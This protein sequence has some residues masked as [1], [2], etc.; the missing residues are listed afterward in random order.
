MRI[1]FFGDSLTEGVDGAPYLDVLAQRAADDPRLRGVELVNAGI[2]GDT[3]E[4]L[5]ARVQRDVVARQ[6]DAVLVQVGNNDCTTLLM[7]RRL[8]TLPNLRTRYY[9]FRRKGVR[10]AVTP[11]RYAAALRAIVATLRAR[12]PAARIALCTPPTIG[13]APGSLTWRFLDRYAD[14][15]RTVAAE[16]ATD[17]LDLRAAFAREL[18][19]LPPAPATGVRGIAN[20][21]QARA[22]R[23]Q[24]IEAQAQARGLRLTYDSLHFT[25]RGAELMAGVIWPWVVTVA[26]GGENA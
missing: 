1:V 16:C 25:A 13:E 18:E 24:G 6:S 21:R 17:L 5:L 8:P 14:A 19:G 2:G 15:V 9:F 20:E 3:A 12:C 22:V 7:R 26:G 11:D 23:A 4:H 10:G